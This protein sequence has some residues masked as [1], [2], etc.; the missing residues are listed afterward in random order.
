VNALDFILIGAFAVAAVGGYRLGFMARVTSWVGLALGLFVSARL[1]PTLLDSVSGPDPAAK[2]FLA[3][4]ILL[5]GAFLGQALGLLLGHAVRKAIPLGPVAA[6]DKV[7]GAL[8]GLLGI[9]VMVWFLAP[10]MADVPGQFSRLARESVIARTVN[11]SLPQAPDT[12]QALRRLV[13]E[14]GYPRVFNNFRSSPSIGLPPVASGLAPEVVAR[15]SASTVKVQGVACRRIQE[16]SGFT[17][18]PDLVVT[19]AHVVAGEKAT[20]VLRPDGKLLKAVVVL[21][22]S[23]R[24]IALLRVTGLGQASLA[25][26]SGKVGQSGAVF[27]HP[28][29]QIPLHVAPAK[30]GQEVDARGRDLY[31]E[32]GTSRDVFILAAELHPGDS[33]GALVD[34]RGEVVGVAFAIAPDKPGTAYALSNKELNGA[35]AEPR[36]ASGA[37]TGPCLTKA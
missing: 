31:D 6:L 37:A 33:G 20:E 24:D 10:A 3:G 14:N 27:G 13:G 9:L 11:E 34:T 17:V 1:L 25:V 32:H 8:V 5:A 26:G 18:G 21:F 19:N 16:G 4:G 28:G 7:V 35:L 15:V 30:I 29:G 23:D 22:D 2:F 36:A 12:L